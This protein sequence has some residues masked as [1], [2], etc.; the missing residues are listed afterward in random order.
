[1]FYRPVFSLLMFADIS[2]PISSYQVFSYKVPDHLKSKVTI[3]L[4]VMAPVRNRKVQGIIVAIKNA[5]DYKGNIREVESL[6]DEFPVLDDQL[7]D[8][9]LWLADYYNTPLGVAAKAALP[10]NL[11][12]KYKPRSQLFVKA[13][14]G[15]DPLATN[16]KS[17][18]ALLD[19]LSVKNEF[20][21]ASTLGE[22]ASNP[23]EVSR[24]LAEKGWVELLEKPVLPDLTGLSLNPIYK[25]VR[26]TEYQDKALDQ[27]KV[28]MDGDDFSPFLLHGVTGS[29]KTEIYIEAARHGIKQN[30]SI[31]MLLPEIALTPQIAGR[32]RAAF[33]DDVALWH[34]KLSQSARAWTW[35]KICAGDY[36]VVVGARS[37]IFAPLKNLGLIVVDEEQES[38]YKQDSPDPRYH[39]RDVALMRGKIHGATVVLASATPSMESYYNH[40][41][42]KFGYIHLPERFGGAKYPHVHVVDMIKESEETEVYGGIFSRRLLEKIKD[43]LDKNEQIILLHNRRGFAPVLRCDDCGEVSTCPHCQVALTFHK[44]GKYLQCHFCNH[45]QRN[46][47]N[48]CNECHSINIK[49]AGIGTQK[50]ED[51]LI[52]QFPDATI[53]RLDGDVIRS[54]LNIS[55][56]LQQF[57]DGNIDILLGTQM[58]AKGLDFANATLVGIINGDTGLYLPDFRAGEKV[59]QLIYQAAG[60]SGR[61]RIPGEVV[62]QTYNQDNAVIQCATQLDLKKYY[63]ICLDERQA[64]SYPPF[65]WIVRLEVRGKSKNTVEEVAA[66]L[67]SRFKNTPKGIEILGP[68]YCYREKLRD[69]YRMQIVL[70]SK[71]Q[72]DPNGGKLHAY[73]KSIIKSNNGANLKGGLRLIVDVNPVSLL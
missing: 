59:F 70:K 12:T 45:I 39:A 40:I 49:L 69:Y 9:I 61:G 32:F 47:P 18:I 31:I 17:Q 13:K 14:T 33:G 71:K 27:L 52:E 2:F 37:A 23:I 43:R 55:E 36:K 64:L 3:G 41:N 25:K 57:S 46:L 8:L 65:S 66:R 35:K 29:G 10:A 44:K 58:I 28:S 26:F 68:S 56:V 5:S 16:A 54:G 67:K 1:M 60:R 21:P 42:G 20:I 11:S 6:V 48:K 53:T 72:Y 7:W 24:K 15:G 73:Y 19:H 34:S 51:E 62:V 22:F 50:V 30:K 38:A 4:R 63:N